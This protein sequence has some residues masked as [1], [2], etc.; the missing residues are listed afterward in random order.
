MKVPKAQVVESN[1][2]VVTVYYTIWREL[3]GDTEESPL[4][5]Y[6]VYR[7]SGGADL[8]VLGTRN[9]ELDLRMSGSGRYLRAVSATTR[10]DIVAEWRYEGDVTSESGVSFLDKEPGRLLHVRT[11]NASLSVLP[12]HLV[13]NGLNNSSANGAA[14][15]A[16][17]LSTGKPYAWG[18]FDHGGY[19]PPSLMELDI[20]ELH[21]TTFAFGALR[22][23]GDVVLWGDRDLGGGTTPLPTN[24]AQLTGSH[25]AFACVKRD[26]RLQAW[27]EPTS[28][29]TLTQEA[30]AVS[31][32][33]S[34]FANAWGFCAMRTNGHL[35]S[36]G[37]KN[38]GGE[39]P[40]ELKP[41]P[42]MSVRGNSSAFCALRTTGVVKAWGDQNNGGKLST[43]VENASNIV[44][45]AASTY[46][47]FAVLTS[48]RK[49]LAWGRHDYGGLVPDFIKQY[50]DIVEVVGIDYAFCAR[51]EGGQIVCWGLADYGG[52]RP[53]EYAQEKFVQVTGT[54][55]AFAAL[56]ADGTVVTWGKG[57]RGGDSSLVQSEL[58]DIRA[59]Y[60]NSQAFAA[61][62]A[63]GGVVTWGLAAGGGMLT[64]D[65][66]AVLSA[67]LRY[68]TPGS[69]VSASSP[70]GRALAAFKKRR[71]VASAVS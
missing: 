63:G 12:L 56:R 34:V 41:Y 7:E 33:K 39:I 54:A 71:M 67:Y 37:P 44:E 24:V 66:K 47:A 2:T 15:F 49:V 28:G 16:A 35:L 40:T 48:E 13:G 51:R 3:T 20:E 5:V 25:M 18:H 8:I 58:V 60:A 52:V 65:Q 62:P 23:N 64:P 9:G 53:P 43:E 26:G 55:V 1:D 70:Q 46:G 30:S 6:E 14:A 59:I 10:D 19:I 27:G 36:W 50:N 17:R 57:D 38:Y 68:D 29:G 11:E 45:I 22:S 21:L 4:S 61:I 42:H 31:D 69:A 32:A